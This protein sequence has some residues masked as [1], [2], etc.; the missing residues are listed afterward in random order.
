MTISNAELCT[1]AEA[2]L[3]P[4]HLGDVLV[5]DVACALVTPDGRLFTGA[6][7][8]GHL[9][10]CAEQSAVSA[11]V[12]VAPP[13]ISKLVA[14]WRDADGGLHALPPCGRCREFLRVL[15]QDNLRTEIVLG[16]DRSVT[17]EEL[18]P[19]YGWRSELLWPAGGAPAPA[20]PPPGENPG[21]AR[22]HTS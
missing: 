4:Q 22:P 6:C 2:A 11:M 16:P 19:S 15:S 12:S 5:A 13:T 3:N 10:L 18:L 14:V 7:I 21:R 9:G 1:A 8:G 20:G 17:L